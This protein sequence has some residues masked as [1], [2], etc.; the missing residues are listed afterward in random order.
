MS[1][2]YADTKIREALALANGSQSKARQIIAMMAQQDV[3]LLLALTK[4]HLDGIVAFH[5]ERVATGRAPQLK[6][7]NIVNEDMKKHVQ[8]ANP[9]GKEILKA[10]TADRAEIFGFDSGA[11]TGR[12]G[13]ASQSHVNALLQMV[14]RSKHKF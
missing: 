2:E 7:A 1:T 8:E 6:P 5:V 4:N 13:Q 14:E 12:R 9:F 10:V 11:P 3:K